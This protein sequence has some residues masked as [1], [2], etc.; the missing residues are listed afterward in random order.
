MLRRLLPL[1]SL[2]VGCAGAAP[3]QPVSPSQT[4]APTATPPAASAQPEKKAVVPAAVPAPPESCTAYTAH[5]LSGCAPAT[6]LGDSLAAALAKTV[7]EERDAA[8]ACLEAA[9]ELPPG[10][11]R[12]L[13]AELAPVACGDA[14]VVPL[15]ESPPKNLP[16]ELESAMLGLVVSA[17]LARLLSDPPAP[18]A[19][20][21]RDSFRSFFAETLTPW[22]L[23]QAA[24]IEKLSLEGSRLAGYGRGIA[25]IAAGNADLRF[26]EMVR[27]VPLPDEMKADKDVRDAYYGALDGALEPRK[28][29]GR[30][31]ALVGLRAFAEIGAFYDPRVTRA[32]ELLAKLW[33]GSRVDALDRLLVPEPPPLDTSAPQLVVA[34]HLPTF[35]AGYLLRDLDPNEPKVLRAFM[36]QGLAVPLRDKLD[37]AEL[38]EPVRLLYARIKLE[39]G[40]RFFRASDF[41]R[42]HALLAGAKSDDARLI[43]ALA[44]A[45]KNGP[46]DAAELM[47]KGPFVKG[48]GDVSALDAE[49]AK[50]GRYAGFAAFDAAY[51]LQLAPKPDDAAYWDELATRFAAAEKLLK[52]RSTTSKDAALPALRAREYADAARATAA[53]IRAK[54]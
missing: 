21:T 14:L 11:V 39:S 42:A 29:R 35:Y 9:P 23:A 26:V 7:A 46:E 5:A 18:P 8:L 34:A 10:T 24:A 51:V 22:V 41:Q 47:L 33:S 36:Q 37:K 25:A 54:K 15:L 1:L 2:L 50:R 43:A 32:R 31:A 16:R 20:V 38:S 3:P 4:P 48:T 45:L 17:R 49:A 53:A 28:V 13:R 30:D 52:P 40:R 12:A 44:Q 27:E 6:P 19:P